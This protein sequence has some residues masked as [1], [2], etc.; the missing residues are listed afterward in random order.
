MSEVLA[1]AHIYTYTWLGACYLGIFPLLPTLGVHNSS[2]LELDS[3]I[4]DFSQER[5]T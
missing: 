3:D 4:Y 5:S 1:G 2:D